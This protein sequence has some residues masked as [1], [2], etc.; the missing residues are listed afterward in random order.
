M[1][2]FLDFGTF[3]PLDTLGSA[4][5]EI[6]NKLA[7]MPTAEIVDT[8]ARL[9]AAAKRIE[10]VCKSGKETLGL[11]S[12]ANNSPIVDGILFRATCSDAVRWTLDTARVKEELGEDWYNSHCKQT[13]VR[14]WRFAAR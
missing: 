7:A 13:L 2:T 5:D 10:E 1:T 9:N 6:A 12:T 11:V 3:P 8:L 4:I 14:S